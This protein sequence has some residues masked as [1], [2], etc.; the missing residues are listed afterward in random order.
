MDYDVIIIGAGPAGLIAGQYAAK[1]GANVL[2]MDKKNVLGVPVR[3]GEAVIEK[4]FKDFNIKPRKELISNIVNTMK[5]YSSKGKKLEVKLNLN[6]YI[7]D[8]EKFEQHLGLLA[9]KKGAEIM[10][11]ATVVKLSKNKVK[12]VDETK[13]SNVAKEITGRI[14]IG[15]DGVESRVG[16]WAGIKTS[17]KPKDIAV[18]R[19]YILEGLELEENTVEFYWGRKYSQHGYIWVFPKSNNSANVGIVS[20]GGNNKDIG[21][22][23]DKFIRN[24]APSAKRLNHIAGCVPQAIPPKK[25]VSDNVMLVGD[26]ARVAIP[27]TG[28]GIGHAMISGSWAGE[29]A[30]RVCAENKPISNL[31]G[32]EKKMNTLRRKIKRAHMLYNVI[33]KDDEIFEL[34]FGLFIPLQLMYEF[35]P[36]VIEKFMLRGLRY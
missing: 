34:L 8:R 36:N 14:I 25:L 18:C 24:R 9:T 20:P 16:R 17:L 12:F 6:G 5:C 7:L 33:L 22:L 26:A 19:Q 2:I 3:C 31:R 28:G 13:G 10:L 21:S 27:V 23:L 1:Q 32:F 29:L 35:S 4:V 15:A 30:G 11:S